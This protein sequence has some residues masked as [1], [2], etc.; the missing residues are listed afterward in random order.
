MYSNDCFGPDYYRTNFAPGRERRSQTL[1]NNFR[2]FEPQQLV[3]FSSDQARLT[4]P[5]THGKNPKHF[6]SFFTGFPYN[7]FILDEKKIKS[8]KT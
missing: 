2:H 3:R 8:L 5:F 6:S 4:L 7:P 1:D